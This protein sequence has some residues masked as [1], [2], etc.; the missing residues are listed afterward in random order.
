[1]PHADQRRR[2]LQLLGP[3]T[4]GIR[5]H[6]A[7]LA[8][9]L[10]AMGWDVTVVGSPRVM[11]GV[12]RQDGVVDVPPTWNVPAYRSA[13]RRLAELVE[14]HD[15]IH[16]H[17]LKAAMV[18]VGSKPRPPMVLTVHNLVA[19]TQPRLV[20]PMFER[21]ESSLVE[22]SDHVIV[23]SDEIAR[24]FDGIVS[25]DHQTFVLPASPPRVPR[26][27]VAEVRAE[28]GV[29][30]APLIVIVARHHRQKRLTLF[31]DAMAQVHRVRPD[32]RALM[33]GDGPEHR[34]LQQR[35]SALGLDGVVILTGH[36][37]DPADEMRAA[38]VV[39]L[40][41]DWEGSPLVVA[42]CLTLGRPLV[43]TA[44]GTVTRHLVDGVSA[45]ITPI[46]DVQAFAAALIAVLGDP[47]GAR[48]MAEAGRVV[49]AQHFD[50]DHL[51]AAV[52][53]V[54]EVVVGR[55]AGARS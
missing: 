44:V 2:V 54:Y 26:R 15:L 39:A 3:S 10:P 16:V 1:M 22:R 31:L 53:A 9:R 21:L 19:G 49:A 18:A 36:L 47:A 28:Y 30:D 46:G 55:V 17:G 33:I 25:P 5:L 50:P 37:P 42:E 4:G 41:S 34:D 24:R 27:P 23:I 12:G 40:S 35:C 20:R 48:R 52:A 43:T 38:D 11:Q 13:R 6:V 8:T 45:R 14:G 7:E 32:V 29:G 51:V